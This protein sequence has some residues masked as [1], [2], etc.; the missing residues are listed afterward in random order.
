M[1]S[2][3]ASPLTCVK[4]GTSTASAE[5]VCCHCRTLRFSFCCCS[6]SSAKLQFTGK[7]CKEGGAY[8]SLY[9][10]ERVIVDCFSISWGISFLQMW[11]LRPIPSL[12]LSE[13]ARNK[14]SEQIE[15]PHRGRMRG[16]RVSRF[17]STELQYCS[18]QIAHWRLAALVVYR[19]SFFASESSRVRSHPDEAVLLLDWRDLV[20]ERSPCRPA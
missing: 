13:M 1:W 5:G 15:W 17:P 10:L 14:H 11:Q 7:P 2:N 16:L 12:R 3:I 9:F 4:P 8:T 20:A 6:A 18:K 19:R